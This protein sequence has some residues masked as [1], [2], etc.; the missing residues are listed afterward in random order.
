MLTSV[1]RAVG[2]LPQEM[3]SVLSQASPAVGRSTG[4][5]GIASI[6]TVKLLKC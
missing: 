2:M 5:C 4:P 6:A 1:P 3:L